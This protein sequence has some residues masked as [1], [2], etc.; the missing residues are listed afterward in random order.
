MLQL[1]SAGEE[2]GAPS[3]GLAQTQ[4]ELSCACPGCAGIQGVLPEKTEGE[5]LELPLLG[6]QDPSSILGSTKHG[7]GLST[8]VSLGV[9]QSWELHPPMT[10]CSQG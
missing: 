8:P 6:L 1:I 10:A 5:L 3:S 2:T 7:L 9:H 4:Q